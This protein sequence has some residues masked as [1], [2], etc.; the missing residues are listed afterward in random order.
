MLHMENYRKKS[1]IR[2]IP[3]DDKPVESEEYL[4]REKEDIL[5]N[6]YKRQSGVLDILGLFTFSGC[7]PL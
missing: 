7:L 5:S 3:I 1:N 6:N 4:V 2:R